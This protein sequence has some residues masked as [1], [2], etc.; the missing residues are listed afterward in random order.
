MRDSNRSETQ[1]VSVEDEDGERDC[2]M[3]AAKGVNANGRRMN[4]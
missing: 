1:N 3:E 4:W 2:K